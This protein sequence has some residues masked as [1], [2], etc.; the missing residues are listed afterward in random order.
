MATMIITVIIVALLML[1][2]ISS[3]L[4][5]KNVVGVVIQGGILETLIKVFR[6]PVAFILYFLLVSFNYY[7]LPT[8]RQPFK[9][10]IPGSVFVAVGMLVVTIVYVIYTNFVVDYNVIYGS[11]AS[12]VALMIWFYFISWVLCIGIFV[13]RVWFMKQ[14]TEKDM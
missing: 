2:F 4:I 8:V 3:E 1:V 10:I 13:N 11:L 6:W 14:I 5:F 9:K 7:V 12:I